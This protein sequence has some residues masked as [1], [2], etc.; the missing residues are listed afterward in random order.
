MATAT[1]TLTSIEEYLST[2]YTPDM[3]YKNGELIGRNVG[4]QKHGT[5]QMIIGAYL[6]SARNEFRT[7]K[8][9]VETRL[10][11]AAERYVVPDVIVVERPYQH[12]LEV[13]DIPAVVIE[14]K[15]P[16]DR[17]DEIIG[18]C[19]EYAAVGVP[20][21]I[22][23]DPDSRRQFVFQNDALQSVPASIKLH[24]PKVNMAFS[25]PMDQIFEALDND[26]TD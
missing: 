16:T 20:N 26:E 7:I 21:I 19:F 13:T 14:V 12:G 9:F 25:L 11:I 3:E 1:H 23:I 8:A 17:F 6:L 5:L 22:V 24:L 2:S 18:K 15:S 4:T 10:R